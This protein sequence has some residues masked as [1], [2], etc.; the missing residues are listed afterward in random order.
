[1]L[2]LRPALCRRPPA[3]AGW[4]TPEAPAADAD[5]HALPCPQ[6]G[7]AP[8]LRSHHDKHTGCCVHKHDHHCW[9]LS[10]TIGEPAVPPPRAIRTT[11]PL[12]TGLLV[13]RQNL[14]PLEA[15]SACLRQRIPPV[16]AAYVIR[17]PAQRTLPDLH[18]T[19]PTRCT[20]AGDRNHARF[21]CFLVVQSALLMW[22]QQ[23]LLPMA[24]RCGLLSPGPL[25]WLS[26][27]GLTTPESCAAGL[28]VGQRAALLLLLVGGLCW[29]ALHLHLLTLH[30]YLAA[31]NQTTLELLKVRSSGW[32]VG[33]GMRR[34]T[35]A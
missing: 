26:V 35:P 13:S 24:L 19:R 3:A 27:W 31:T 10:A 15:P 21:M 25:G 23:Q 4:I 9:F 29:L 17:Q 22:L 16:L 28:G 11:T 32:R 30:V 34:A 12:H 1:M 7:E 5:P 8:S 20:L 14:P 6:C 33:L 2:A 18:E